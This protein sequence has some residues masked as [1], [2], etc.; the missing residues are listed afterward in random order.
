[1]KVKISIVTITYNSVRTLKETF[2]SILAQSYRPIEYIIVDGCSTD[3][4]IK[5]INQYQEIF[6]KH[7]I[8]V[9]FKSERDAGIS[10]AF[11]KGIRQATGDIVGIINSDDKLAPNA[12]EIIASTY[13]EDVGVY[14]GKCI[15]FN[16]HN[17][18]ELVAI[19]KFSKKNTSLI[20]GM[21]IYHPAT[22]VAKFIYDLYGVYDNTYKM[23]M[24]RELLLRLYCNGV[25]FLYINEVLACYREGGTNQINYSK[26]A[27]EN[28]I[29][30]VKYGMNRFKARYYKFYFYIHDIM[31]KLIQKMRLE[32]IIHKKAK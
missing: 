31:W 12:L 17:K 7:N 32:K 25:K 29:I 15:I 16:D 2:E 28:E 11:N 5:I 30:S 23:C 4:T 26:T 14:Y 19:P 13:K 22:F 6:K 27:D 1:M 24:D 20:V 3:G 8:D 18:E 21:T 9:K 10:D